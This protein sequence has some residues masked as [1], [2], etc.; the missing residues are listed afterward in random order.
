MWNAKILLDAPLE[1]AHYVAEEFWTHYNQIAFPTDRAGNRDSNSRLPR[2]AAG[3]ANDKPV[4]IQI[5]RELVYETFSVSRKG[6]A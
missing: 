3:T 4:I 1:T 2:V 6:A 5:V